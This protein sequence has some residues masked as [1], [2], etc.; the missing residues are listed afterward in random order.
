MIQRE[1]EDTTFSVLISGV[2]RGLRTQLR[3]TVKAGRVVLGPTRTFLFHNGWFLV[4]NPA[5]LAR[6]PQ[7]DRG[8][9]LLSLQVLEGP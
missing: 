3:T 9:T 2:L 6:G 5:R 4:S 8:D 1:R 7:P